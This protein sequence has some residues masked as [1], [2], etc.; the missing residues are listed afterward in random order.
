MYN[1]RDLYYMHICL[2]NYVVLWSRLGLSNP[3]IALTLLLLLKSN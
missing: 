2:K 1:L 3:H